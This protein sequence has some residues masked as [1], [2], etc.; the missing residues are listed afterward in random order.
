[1]SKYVYVFIGKQHCD[2]QGYPIL[3]VTRP[4]ATEVA[5]YTIKLS[6]CA[7]QSRNPLLP[8]ASTLLLQTFLL[9]RFLPQY[10]CR[11]GRAPP[12]RNPQLISQPPTPSTSHPVKPDRTS[13]TGKPPASTQRPFDMII[14]YPLLLPTS[15]NSLHR[16]SPERGQWRAGGVA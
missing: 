12:V 10:R 1:M 16:Q 14:V 11:I 15:F 6:D 2:S 8:F 5:S 4:F 3:F 7:I 13:V 9:C